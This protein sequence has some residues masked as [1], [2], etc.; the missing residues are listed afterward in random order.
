MRFAACGASITGPKHLEQG[1][2][3]QDAMSL[4]GWRGVCLAVVADG[5]GSRPRSD[6]GA[7]RACQVARRVLRAADPAV[8]LSCTL[9]LIHQQWLGAIA[10]D[11]PRDA[12]T[13]ILLASVS[14]TGA[15]RAA[16][17]GDG[18]L[19]MRS[20]GRFRCITP[21]REG[22][23]NQTWALELEHR[24]EKWRTAE[25]KLTQ[26]GDGIVL[27]TDGIADDLQPEHLSAFVDALYK[28]V[29][30]RSRRQ[31]RRWLKAEFE[32]WATPMHSDDKTLVA[33]FRTEK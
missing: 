33:V 27:L 25:G 6:M 28:D 22:Y 23:G 10:P 19:L 24:P 2:V 21:E 32:N 9:K 3:N 8:D 29:K 18:L 31:G 12:A 1:E 17:L 4:T 26:A 20:G 7:W 5:L 16:Q 15:V 11:T 13:T 14:A 30:K